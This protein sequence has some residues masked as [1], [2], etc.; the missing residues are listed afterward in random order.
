MNDTVLITRALHFAA[1][2]HSNHRRKGQAQEPYVNHLA[3]VAELV[4]SATEGKDANL[5]A[6]ALL[7]D[8]IEDTVTVPEELVTIFNSD[9]ARLVREVTDDKSLPKQ[10][11]KDLQVANAPEKS[12]RAKLLKLADK[13]SNLRSIASSP[14]ENWNTERKQEY[15]DWSSKVGAGLK[16]VNPW[17]EAR[18]CEALA[19]AEQA[20]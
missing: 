18:F 12:T 20:L 4:A 2:R 14:P 10:D 13:T 7:H 19:Q 8:T 3:E 9:V 16:G 11:R 15:I 1:E 17:L 6:A 5:V